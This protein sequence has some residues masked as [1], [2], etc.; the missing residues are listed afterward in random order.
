M[1]IFHRRQQADVAAEVDPAALRNPPRTCLSC[2]RARPPFVYVENG[3]DYCVECAELSLRTLGLWP[4]GRRS[5]EIVL[6]D[7]LRLGKGD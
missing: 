7:L 3:H 5:D 2:N 6:E 4:V 1:G